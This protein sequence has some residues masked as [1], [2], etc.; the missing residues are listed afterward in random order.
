[1]GSDFVHAR[2]YNL[3]PAILFKGERGALVDLKFCRLSGSRSLSFSFTTLTPIHLLNG[4]RRVQ[5]EGCVHLLLPLFYLIFFE[6]IT[7][8]LYHNCAEKRTRTVA[9]L[10]WR[11]SQSLHYGQTQASLTLCPIHI[12]KHSKE[13]IERNKVL[14]CILEMAYLP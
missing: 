4:Y 10:V 11:V 1:M 12:I 2:I 13:I 5:T 6:F 7:T 3:I 8:K 9:K 14:S